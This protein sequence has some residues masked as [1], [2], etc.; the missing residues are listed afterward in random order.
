VRER[1]ERCDILVVG[2]GIAG[3]SLA[4]ALA[5]RGATNVVV[6]EREPAP[7]LHA[8]GR[9]A[10]TLFETDPNPTIQRLKL[11]AAPF[12]KSPPA[13]FSDRP[14]LDRRGALALV[15]A[16]AAD[17]TA[18]TVE[19]LKT[20]G[21]ACELL[22]AR[23]A[24]ELCAAL[25]G[26]G[27]AAAMHLPESGFIDVDGLVAAYVEHARNAGVRFLHDATVDGIGRNVN[28]KPFVDAGG[29]RIEADTIVNA[30]GAWAGELAAW[31]GCAPLALTP[32]RRS[33]ALY[34]PP[35]AIETQRWPLVL[36]EERSVYF[37]PL[38]TELMLCPMDAESSP[39]C[40][41]RP[42]ARVFDDARARLASIAPSLAELPLRRAWAG[43][44][45]F[46]ADGVPVVGRDARWPAVFWLAGQGGCGIET[47]PLMAEVAADL[48]LDGTTNRFDTDV[49]APGRFAR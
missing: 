44:R 36:S 46:S 24:T 39:P 42:V 16:S 30:A 37:R 8:S 10:R 21:V 32:L 34:E 14:L 3:T 35:P 1:V 15:S 11:A 9:S 19:R 25:D 17:A 33:L 12:F 22:T 27:F 45:T 13:G 6:V 2:A 23:A 5:R 29:A 38:G 28:G 4:W 26:G 41:A 48:L 7:A 20:E 49:L 47:S 40:D 43:L 31:A 18:A